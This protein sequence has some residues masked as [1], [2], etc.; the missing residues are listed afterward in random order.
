[1]RRDDGI[2]EAVEDA[3]HAE[4]GAICAYTGRRIQLRAGPP[5]EVG[6]H[7][8][9]VK[10]QAHCEA[11]E[12]T[13]YANLVACWPRPN[14]T[15]DATDGAVLKADW[16]SPEQAHLFVSPLRDDCT[17][18]FAFTRQGVISEAQ[19]HDEAAKETIERLGLGLKEL[20]SLRKNAIHGALNLAGRPIRLGEAEKLRR[21]MDRDEQDL[22]SGGP[23]R[24]MPFSFAIR[25][26]IDREIVKLKAIQ[27]R[28]AKP[29]RHP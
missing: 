23:V 28:R 27:A 7:M 19:P 25:P 20:T 3:L 10:P 6:F 26:Q 9:H 22:N 16:P 14:P 18:R 17:R 13:D 11:G 1:M 15:E 4:Q 8:E 24:L 21:E 5:R 2:R 12:D 29:N